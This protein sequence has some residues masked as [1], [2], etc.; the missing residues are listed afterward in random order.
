MAL[1]N[2]NKSALK[3]NILNTNM[4]LPHLGVLCIELDILMRSISVSVPQRFYSIISRHPTE[5]IVFCL[6]EPFCH[7]LSDV[8]NVKELH[9][10]LL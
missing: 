6:K 4:K 3:W 2:F 9:L 8:Q 7:F 1:L 10:K 5:L